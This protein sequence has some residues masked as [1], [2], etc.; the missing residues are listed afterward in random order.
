MASQIAH[1]V[2]AKKYLEKYPRKNTD[3]FILGC[4]FPDIRRVDESI[5]RNDT[6]FCFGKTNLD[7]NNLSPFLAGW[8]FHLYCDTRREE[9]LNNHKFYGISGAKDCAG[10]PNKLLEDEIIHNNSANW[11]ELSGLFNNVPIQKILE[12]KRL[13]SVLFSEMKKA[14]NKNAKNVSRETIIFWYSIL[15][16]YIEKKPDNHSIK[17]F[18]SGQRDTENVE[19]IIKT[20]DDLRKNKKAIKIL[21]QVSKEIV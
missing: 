8:K 11:K 21:R 3:E 7:F 13:I 15:A 9:I 16:K 10:L 19:K 5:R 18:L 17:D 1:I 4:A 6:H 2:Y 12:E 20:I 14:G